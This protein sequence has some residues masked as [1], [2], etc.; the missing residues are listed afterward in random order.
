MTYSVT[1][2]KGKEIAIQRMHPWIFSGAL[3]FKPKDIPDGSIVSV[4][5]YQ[6]E[7]IAYGHF[8]NHSSICVRVLSMC[9][10]PI[11]QTFWDQRIAAAN[12]LRQTLLFQ[13]DIKTNAYRLIHGEGDGLPGL[14]IDIYNDITVI[15]PHTSGMSHSIPQIVHAIQQIPT[16]PSSHIFVKNVAHKVHHIEGNTIEG[17]IRG[18][19]TET[20]ISE[21]G[22]KFVVNVAEGQKT[23]FFLDQR[24]N[25][26]LLSTLSK[27][28]H[29]LNCFAYTGGFSVYA[30]AGGAA[31]VTSVDISSVAMDLCADNIKL[32]GTTLS[33]ENITADVMT[34]LKDIAN[35]QYDII[36][37]DPP[38]FAKNISKKHNAVQAYKRLNVLAMSKVKS[39]G[40][41]FTFS[42]SQVVDNKLFYDTI[43]SAGMETKRSFKV[44]TSLSQG[45][46]HPVSLYHNEGH[47]LKGLVLYV[48]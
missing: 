32:N 2:A 41:L 42:C 10:Q 48:E 35:N 33:Y 8:Q 27:D 20:I 13:N 29:I 21:Y 15:Q 47:Y 4:K 26:K 38:A 43:V 30:L 6:D 22:N 24:D 28:K 11:D 36:V 9:N 16:L 19:K 34:Y 1:L 5:N 46:D 25:R 31:H 17:L 12:R 3:K 23:G 40:L 37:V 39:G 44:I 14:I 18:E 45:A 7:V